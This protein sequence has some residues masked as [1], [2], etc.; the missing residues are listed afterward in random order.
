M[1]RK[2]ILGFGISLDGYIARR[3][4]AMD[5]LVKSQLNAR[6]LRRAIR[7][8]IERHHTE[9]AVRQAEQKCHSVFDHLIEGIRDGHASAV[10]A[11]SIFHFGEQTIDG[12][13]AALAAAG[14][15]VRQA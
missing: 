13:K 14:I 1:P 4:G 10:L 11:A 9:M 2:V 3:N 12:A 7:Y 5:Y 6:W 8:A 15:P